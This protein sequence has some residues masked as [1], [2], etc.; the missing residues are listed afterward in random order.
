MEFRAVTQEERLELM[1]LQARAF[2][3]AYDRKKY[4]EEI[5]GSDAWMN[6]RAAF[7]EKGNLVAGLDL[8]PFDAWFDG[9]TVGMGG[10]GGIASRAEDRNSG[11]VRGL[12]ASALNEMRERGDVFSVLVPFS[13]GY[14]RK[15]GYEA[16][17][18]LTRVA[19]PLEPL[20]AFR[21]PG[22]AERFVPGSGGSDPA[23]IIE[24]YNDFASQYNLCVDRQGWRWRALLERDPVS[25]R[26]HAYVWYA[27]DG[28]PGAYI[29]F[30]AAPEHEA[31]EMHVLEAAWRDRESLLGLLG[32]L[33][34]FASNL[35]KICWE[36]P[37]TLRPELIWPEIREVKTELS[38]SCMSRVVHAQKALRFLKKPEGKG[39]VNISVR[40]D[41]LPDNTG[42]Y[43]VEWENGEGGARKV[44]SASADLECSVHALAQ[45]A[46]GYLPFAQLRLRPDV[47]VHGK[48]EELEKLFVRKDVYLIDKF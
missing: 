29:L 16:C 9:N 11:N 39:S 27:E 20:K 24:V 2:F 40:D 14:Y 8:L 45:L 30:K 5:A 38:C 13:F 6:G 21:Q 26:R 4:T 18:T 48:P 15:F 17:M 42:V 25:S 47:E 3:F 19:A 31:S 32:F 28:R 1:D 35:T 41:F 12:M 36:L 37:P 44:K 43:K 23:P 22:H 46:V 34:A 7:D 10:V 33:G